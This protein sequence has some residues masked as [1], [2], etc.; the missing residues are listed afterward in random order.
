MFRMPF[1]VFLFWFL[2]FLG[3]S[4]GEGCPLNHFVCFFSKSRSVW[5]QGDFSCFF[6]VV[7]AILHRS[8]YYFLYT[9]ICSWSFDFVACCKGFFLILFISFR[10]RCSSWL[11][12]AVRFRTNFPTLVLKTGTG[13][14]RHIFSIG[15]CVAVKPSC[16]R[17]V[18]R[19][20]PASH[21]RSW[22]PGFYEC[23]FSCFI[24][25][26]TQVYPRQAF[27]VSLFFY[28]FYL[29]DTFPRYA[30]N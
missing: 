6:F 23:H 20:N 2:L 26:A 30:V 1:S 25:S 21:W 28:S 24:P 22:A 13:P 3:G 10:R 18:L 15:S 19:K 8:R 27:F 4:G 7:I 16:R 9:G 11:V 17:G 14:T 5:G 29:R 12:F